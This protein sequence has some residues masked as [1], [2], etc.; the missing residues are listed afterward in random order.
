MKRPAENT[1]GISA[2]LILV[3]GWI[4]KTTANIEIPAEVVTAAVVLLGAIPALVTWWISRR[5]K[6]GELGSAH[7][8]E[9]IKPGG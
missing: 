3:V 5:Q 1:S 8:G 4:V 2:A 6:A 7:D 9:V